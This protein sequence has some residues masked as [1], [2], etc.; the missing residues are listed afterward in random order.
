MQCV[1]HCIQNT[2][3]LAAFWKRVNK[4]HLVPNK[5]MGSDTLKRI[6]TMQQLYYRYHIVVKTVKFN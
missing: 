2:N 6:G 3:E 4:R 5:T 1:E